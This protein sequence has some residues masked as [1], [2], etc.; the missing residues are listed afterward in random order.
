ML[1]SAGSILY[2]GFFH[3]LPQALEVNQG[4][5]ARKQVVCTVAAGS[6]FA[7]MFAFVPHDH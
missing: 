2:V 6:F 5:A 7:S 1:F 3:M 4:K